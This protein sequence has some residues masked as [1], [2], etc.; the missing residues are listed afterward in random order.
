MFTLWI[1]FSIYIIYKS[2]KA[3]NFSYE[4]KNMQYKN[5]L[6]Y[7]KKS[8]IKKIFKIFSSKILNKNTW[9]IKLIFMEIFLQ[10]FE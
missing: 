2:W 1:F 8:Y 10:V 9:K 7:L 3:L 4:W 5:N 6:I